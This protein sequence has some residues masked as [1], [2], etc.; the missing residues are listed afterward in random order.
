MS[1]DLLQTPEPSRDLRPYYDAIWNDWLKGRDLEAEIAEHR[2]HR[3]RFLRLVSDC[4][5]RVGREN[6]DV[7][8]I[9][10]GTAIDSYIL[11]ETSSANIVG[12][13][14]SLPSLTVAA[15]C[16]KYFARPIGL[17]AGDA[18][19]MP[20]ADATFDIV[21]S[22]GVVEHFPDPTAMLLDQVRV[23]KPDGILII[24]VPQKRTGYTRFKHREMAKGSWPW[25]WETEYSPGELR[26][27][28]RRFGMKPIA[29][30]GDEHWGSRRGSLYWRHAHTRL[31]KRNPLRDRRLFKMME[32]AY[33]R[34]WVMLE[35]KLGHYFLINVT[36]A[37]VRDPHA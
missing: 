22:Q 5:A 10:S 35:E 8:E 21:Y 7:L 37:F 28:G 18:T 6:A 15:R 30:I 25:G 27:L 20:F 3:S 23:L 17:A 9:G 13:D 16:A 11:A 12:I 2:R 31:Q 14:I 36:M 24:N 26:Q 29:V 19:A 33:D 4:L 1:S 32:S 34:S